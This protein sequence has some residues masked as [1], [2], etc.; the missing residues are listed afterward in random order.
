[1]IPIP[2]HKYLL[3]EHKKTTNKINREAWKYVKKIKD[4]KP[5]EKQFCFYLGK[6]WCITVSQ[7]S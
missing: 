5:F 1:M 2:D 7:H 6:K 3:D 4:K